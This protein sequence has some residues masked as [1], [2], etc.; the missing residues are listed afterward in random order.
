MATKKILKI[1]SMKL[2]GTQISALALAGSADDNSPDFEALSAQFDALKAKI[3]KRLEAPVV[4]FEKRE[5]LR[6]AR[7]AKVQARKDARAQKA[8]GRDTAKAEKLAAK[9]A[10]EEAAEVATAA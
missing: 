8:L 2:L 4:R 9:M 5:A 6:L 7:E 10:K 3:V 1:N